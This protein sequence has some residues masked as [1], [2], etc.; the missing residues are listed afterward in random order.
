MFQLRQEYASGKLANVAYRLIPNHDRRFLKE[1]KANS[2]DLDALRNN[3]DLLVCLY[4]SLPPTSRIQVRCIERLVDFENSHIEAC[5]IN[6]KA[7]ANL[8][9]FQ[10]SLGEPVARISPFTSW[11]D[12]MLN[13]CIHQHQ[14]ARPEAEHQA[15]SARGSGR[16]FPRELFESVVAMNQSGLESLLCSIL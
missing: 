11:L 13:H 4:W 3:H 9:S 10:L 15:K 12:Q 2:D 14:S 1:K 5:R 16:V 7:W 8:V 6:A